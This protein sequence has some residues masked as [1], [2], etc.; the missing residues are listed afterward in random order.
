MFQNPLM[1]KEKKNSS[2]AKKKKNGVHLLQQLIF[3]MSKFLEN[4]HCVTVYGSKEL[5]KAFFRRAQ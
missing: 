4:I 1:L 5:F 3:A 2:F